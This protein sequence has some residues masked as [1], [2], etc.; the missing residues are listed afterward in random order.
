MKKS[1]KLIYI[2]KKSHVGENKQN[3]LLGKREAT[4]ESKIVKRIGRFRNLIK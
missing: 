2:Y 1:K 3:K 4:C